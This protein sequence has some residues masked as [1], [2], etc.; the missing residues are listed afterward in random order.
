MKIIVVGAGVV[1][2][3]TAFFLESG[4][5]DVTIVERNERAGMETSFANAGQLCHF[6]ARPWASPAVPWMI[7]REFGSS[8]AP[9]LIHPRAEIN[10]WRWLISFL[11]QCRSSKYESTKSNLLRLAMHST[12]LMQELL[13][14]TNVNFD[15][16]SEGILHLFHDQKSFDDAVEEQGQIPDV[17]QRGKIL[18][19][20]ECTALEP[21]LVQNDLKYA[22]G[23]L[24]MHE[25]TGDAHRFTLEL[26]ALLE[27]NGAELQYGVSAEELIFDGDRVIGIGTNT[28]NL[29]ADVVV[30]SAA[31]D[32]VQLLKPA[33]RYLPI[34]P[35]KGYSITVATDGYDGAPNIGINDHGRKIG[36]SRLGDRLRAAG[37]AEFGAREKAPNPA[38][39]EAL[40]KL[41]RE[42]FPSA[43]DFDSAEL[44]AGFRPMTPDCAPIIGQTKY[45]N[46]FINTGH[47]SLGWSLACGSAH[48]I[49]EMIA[50]HIPPIEMSGLT[51]DRF[52]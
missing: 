39:I 16:A 24:H 3:T 21:A 30:V 20:M 11:G 46:L 10:M 14:S 36:F 35:V 28:G 8:G 6:T 41:T 49:A 18:E 50:G 1:G 22:G 31:N 23:I 12:K 5:H 29:K 51:I 25:H 17:E 2:V 43:G 13:E 47:G 15:Y 19:Y 44:W 48:I 7:A 34:Y 4:G 9:Y 32:S 26:S 37:T 45:K 27:Q 52:G 38:R 40:K 33:Y 42:M